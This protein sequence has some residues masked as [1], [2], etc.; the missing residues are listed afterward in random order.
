MLASEEV[1][2]FLGVSF[3]VKVFEGEEL[4]S[5]TNEVLIEV[6]EEEEYVLE[7]TTESGVKVTL[8]GPASSF[9]YTKEEMELYVEEI[10]AEKDERFASSL[11][12][13]EKNWKHI[14][15]H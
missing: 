12:L 8:S 2:D 7:A 6:E 10:L 3:R 4:D 11:E 14:K 1:E 5:I 15:I 13:L 9:S